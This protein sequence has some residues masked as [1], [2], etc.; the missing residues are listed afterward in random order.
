MDKLINIR[1]IILT[2]IIYVCTSISTI[3]GIISVTKCLSK[4]DYRGAIKRLE[5][6]VLFYYCFIC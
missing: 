4:E 6:S 1:G 5:I 3:A 2:V